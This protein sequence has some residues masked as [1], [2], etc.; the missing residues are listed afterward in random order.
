MNA[1]IVAEAKLLAYKAHAGQLDKAGRRYIE[2]V[3]RVAA[4]V[5]DDP[6]AEAVAWLHDILEDQYPWVDEVY[7]DFPREVVERVE[8]LTRDGSSTSDE[9]YADIRTDPIALRVKLA[10]IADNCRADRLAALR[11]EV[12]D[13]LERKYAKAMRALIGDSE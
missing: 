3:K 11:P 8:L 7:Q 9:Y 13:R 2:H 5:A 4:A 1:D 6:M 10:D 12:R